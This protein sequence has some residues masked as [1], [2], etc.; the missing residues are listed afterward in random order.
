MEKNPK[1]DKNY[2]NRAK[3]VLLL[4]FC[5]VVFV[6]L[7][8]F[9]IKNSISY[10][11]IEN[12]FNKFCGLKLELINPNT[13]FNLYADI[14]FKADKINIYNENKTAK[15]LEISNLNLQVKP[16]GFILKKANIKNLSSDFVK[17]YLYK[18]KN[19]KFELFEILKNKDF[20]FLKDNKI[21]LT[22]LD[23]NIKNI[24]INYQ[25]DYKI[26]SKIKLK[27]YDTKINL[28][29]K[30][31]VF[32]LSQEG[33]IETTIQSKTQTSKISSNIESK[34]KSG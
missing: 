33:F 20:K 26:Q 23:S 19:G 17:L 12:S 29:K 18:D 13:D 5:A 14:K 22:R 25:C 1:N 27:F 32:K 11:F 6:F 34:Y 24:E 15:F 30:K 21:T 8:L 4:F 31:K 3:F 16:F 28:S 10:S 9:I 2:I 7:L